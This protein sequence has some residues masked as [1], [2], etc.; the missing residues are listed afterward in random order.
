MKL[1]HA[2]LCRDCRCVWDMRQGAACPDCAG[3][4]WDLIARFLDRESE[5]SIQVHGLRWP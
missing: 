3:Q 1:D 2:V 5:P 4:Q